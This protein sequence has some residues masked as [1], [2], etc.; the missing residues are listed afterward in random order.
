MI[1]KWRNRTPHLPKDQT[2]T[3]VS[4]AVNL[5]RRICRNAKTLVTRVST[6][7]FLYLTS[8]SY[9]YHPTPFLPFAQQPWII[10]PCSPIIFTSL[11]F[12]SPSCMS[13]LYYVCKIWTH[14]LLLLPLFKLKDSR[15]AT[16]RMVINLSNL[17]LCLCL[18]F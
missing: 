8:P 2:L 17:C 18:V 15:V 13:K 10:I 7:H 14:V 12:A 11:P 9:Y 1:R 4:W 5:K 16:V 6:W 3:S